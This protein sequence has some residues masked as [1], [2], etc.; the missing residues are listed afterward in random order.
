MQW[1]GLTLSA[2]GFWEQLQK[3][4]IFF[5]FRL[6][7]IPKNVSLLETGRAEKMDSLLSN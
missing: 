2:G 5:S 7:E 6:K 1:K 4:G 3:V